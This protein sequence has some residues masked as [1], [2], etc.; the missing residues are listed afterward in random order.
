MKSHEPSPVRPDDEDSAAQDLPL[1]AI[2]ADESCLGNGRQGSNPGAAGGLIEYASRATDRIVRHDYWVSE[3]ATTNNRMA[4][5][6]VIEA[7]RLVSRK[8]GR[9]RVVFTSDSKYLIDGMN[10]WVHNWIRRG[11]RRKE[12]AVENVDL[13]KDAVEAAR[14][15]Q[16]EWRWVHGHRG[17]AQNEYANF[18][19]TTAAREQTVS[20]GVVESQ[21]DSWLA[22]ERARGKGHG[23]PQRFPTDAEFRP[24]RAFPLAARASLGQ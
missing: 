7:F 9:F 4:L 5:R 10:E 21:F 11:W 19:A 6:S 13:W 17:H 14:L 22:A 1:L 24:A 23:A 2:Y 16:R 12:G 3:P 18:L 8:G 20:D 15:H